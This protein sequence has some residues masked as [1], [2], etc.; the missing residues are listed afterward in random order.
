MADLTRLQAAVAQAIV[1]I[2]TL[3]ANQ[4]DPAEQAVLDALA[5]QLE[6]EAPP[7]A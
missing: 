3:K 6:A 7:P 2:Q 4:A 5:A 1:L